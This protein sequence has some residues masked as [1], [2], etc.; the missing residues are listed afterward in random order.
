[1]PLWTLVIIPQMM[2]VT[3]II[4]KI[5]HTNQPKPKYLFEDFAILPSPLK[6]I[7]IKLYELC[8]VLSSDILRYVWLNFYKKLYEEKFWIITKKG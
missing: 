2:F 6:N 4:A 1:M 3:G 5:K 7:V 8:R